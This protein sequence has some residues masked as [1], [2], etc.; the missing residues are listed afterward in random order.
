MFKLF[1]SYLSKFMTLQG[2]SR[3][4]VPAQCPSQQ[5][6]PHAQWANPGA[7]RVA[8][9]PGEPA[10]VVSVPGDPAGS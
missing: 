1:A 9:V 5:V 2:A 10:R 3:S 7:C 8:S 4:R 6:Q